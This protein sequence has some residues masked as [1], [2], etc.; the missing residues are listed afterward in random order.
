MSHFLT[1]NDNSQNGEDID[2]KIKIDIGH[3]LY[4]QKGSPQETIKNSE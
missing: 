1:H 2:L 4:E 3:L